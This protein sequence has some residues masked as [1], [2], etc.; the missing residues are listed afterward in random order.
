M[1]DPMK[2]AIPLYRAFGI[3]V[4]VHLLFLLITIPMFLRLMHETKGVFWWFDLFMLSVGI[5]FGI[6]LLHEYGHCFA[7]R[8]VG[9]EASEILLW[10][11]GGL[12]YVEVPHAP[13]PHFLVAAAGPAVNLVI[14]LACA[15]LFLVGGYSPL[16]ALNPFG[17]PYRTPTHQLSDGQ[18]LTSVYGAMTVRLPA[19]PKGDPI[20][21]ID[22]EKPLLPG[23]AVWNWRVC[24]MSW[25]LFL[26]NVLIP[27]FPMDGGRMLHAIL[28]DRGDYRS[29]TITA[30][31]V[32]YGA[33]AVML[34]ISLFANETILVGLALFIAINCYRT[35]AMEAETERGAFGY[36]FSQG[37]TSLE[38]DDPPPP[39]PKRKG[40]IRGW[41]DARKARRIQRESDQRVQDDLRMDALLDKIAKQGKNALT[42]EE[43]RFME[44]VSARYRNK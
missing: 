27:A 33:A 22:S 31:Y 13:R 6:V 16:K 19:D 42:D 10:P 35:M 30:C 2:W 29:A 8:R 40:M 24:W 7:A 23:W 25:W 9:G 20:V 12:A 5:V 18:T 17:D 34:G 3:G 15:V 32:G 14:C 26:F 28:W 37:Y 38:R 41:L 21:E 4:K 44:R 11:L 43:R 36:D 1:H 39:R